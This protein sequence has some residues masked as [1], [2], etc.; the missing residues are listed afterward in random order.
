MMTKRLALA[1]VLAGLTACA[2]VKNSFTRPDYEQVDR[3]R[4]KRLVVV[5]QPLPDGKQALGDLWSLIA[6]EYV[7][8]NRNYI[9]KDN[10]AQAEPS[11]NDSL[12]ALCTEGVEGV[13]LLAPQLKATQDGA[14]VAVNARLMRCADGEDTWRA[15]AAGSWGSHDDKF[16]ARIERYVKKLGPEVE[17][18]VVPSYKLLKATLDT[19]PD[20]QLTSEEEDE[21]IEMGE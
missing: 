1:M 3:H 5:T 8:Q 18:F 21:K 17:P 2:T 11:T 4:L 9:V 16:S 15:E 10:V 12:K 20:P 7:Y 6:R 13:L 19:L 14:D